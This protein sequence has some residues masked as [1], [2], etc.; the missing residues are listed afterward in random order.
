MLQS[1]REWDLALQFEERSKG[2]VFILPVN[3]LF[4]CFL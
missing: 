2:L 1:N 4:K 3:L